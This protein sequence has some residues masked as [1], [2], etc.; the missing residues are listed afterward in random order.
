MKISEEEESG[1]KEKPK[2]L[3]VILIVVVVLALEE[4]IEISSET[5]AATE[6]QEQIAEPLQ[7]PV[8]E[9]QS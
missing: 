6:K 7:R 5:E 3:L 9:S 2:S 1:E 4:P 8:S